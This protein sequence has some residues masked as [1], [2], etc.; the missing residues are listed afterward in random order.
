MR[1]AFRGEFGVVRR[2]L[3]RV[4]FFGMSAMSGGGEA[5]GLWRAGFERRACGSVM[6]RP[7]DGGVFSG[8]R[9]R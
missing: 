3:R 2:F 4:G 6:E 7:R 8:S 9:H 5:G 1:A